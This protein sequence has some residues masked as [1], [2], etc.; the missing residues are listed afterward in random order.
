MKLKSFAKLNSDARVL[1]DGGS[2]IF[3][4][5]SRTYIQIVMHLS[6]FP[7]SAYAAPL[8]W[9]YMLVT[10]WAGPRILSR[11]SSE[12]NISVLKGIK[13]NNEDDNC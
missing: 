1:G 2:S 3:C 4:Y 9:M 13:R 6:K 11:T 10:T 8:L 7:M 12:V 5:M